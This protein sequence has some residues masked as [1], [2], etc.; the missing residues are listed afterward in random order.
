MR[1]QPSRAERVLW[2]MLRNRQFEGFKF[3]RQHPIGRYIADFACVSAKVVIETDGPSHDLPEQIAHDLE[4]TAR[5]QAL[6]WHVL[7]VRNDDVLS[8]ESDTIR[9]IQHALLASPSP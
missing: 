6:G 7:R 9:K 4:R 3:R 2:K 5:L 1:R 8:D